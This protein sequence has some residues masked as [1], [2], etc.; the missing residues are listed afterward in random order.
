ME[1]NLK[2]KTAWVFG[3]SRGIGRSIAVELAK[4][5]ANILLIARNKSALNKVFSE[6]SEKMYKDAQ[7]QG[8]QAEASA[9]KSEGDPKKDDVKDADYEVVDDESDKK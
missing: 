2:N 8:A 7:A 6:V 1:I 9:D 4:A 5:G 3:G